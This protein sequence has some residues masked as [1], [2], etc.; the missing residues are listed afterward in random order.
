MLSLLVLKPEYSGKTNVIVTDGLASCNIK[1][2]SVVILRMR[3]KRFIIQHGEGLE[4]QLLVQS[5]CGK[6]IRN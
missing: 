6:K 1:S 2:K 4:F 3:N 5:Q